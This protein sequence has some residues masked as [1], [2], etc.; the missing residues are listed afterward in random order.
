MN[1]G[2]NYNRPKVVG[3][4]IDYINKDWDGCMNEAIQKLPLFTVM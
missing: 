4:I 2:G 3:V 1:A